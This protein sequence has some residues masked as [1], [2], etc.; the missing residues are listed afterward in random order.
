MPDPLRLFDGR[1]LRATLFGSGRKVF[2]TFDNFVAGKAGFTPATA[3]KKVLEAGFAQLVLQTARN[4][5]YLNDE[6]SGLEAALREGLAG[7]SQA[8][9]M[10]F[11][12]GA[13]G[14]ILLADALGVASPCLISPRFP[15][16]LGWTGSARVNCD[17]ALLPAGW[18]DLVTA[19]VAALPA[20]LVLYDA[21]HADDRSA[22]RWMQGVN[23]KIAGA[24]FAFGGHPCTSY[25]KDANR[26][27]ALQEACL[28][29]DATLADLIRVK[30]LARAH[31]PL[32]RAKLA[33]Y[34]ARRKARA[35]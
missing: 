27:A 18:Q 1:K 9:A 14:A 31:A 22:L 30:R 26:F 19:R 28:K 13:F 12:M 4:D 2:V 11:S 15:R 32:Y 21:G 5:W 16:P 23:G 29:P 24:G 20:A 3:S 35:D 33:D 7:F 25:V 6:L 17:P 8:R 34:L 10:G